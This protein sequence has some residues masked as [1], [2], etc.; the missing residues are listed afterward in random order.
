MTQPRDGARHLLRAQH[1]PQRALLLERGAELLLG[2]PGLF[3]ERL[4]GAG[5]EVGI[6]VA[7]A[8]GVDGD[9]ALDDLE[10]ERP[11]E[12]DEPVLGR[13][14]GRD[15]RVARHAGR[16]RD[17]DDAAPPGLQHVGECAPRATVGAREVH[18]E[19]GLPAVRLHLGERH[20]VDRP[21]VV[22][23]H[24]HRPE[25]RAGFGERLLD[26][27]FV[28]H[29]RGHGREALGM[30]VSEFVGE[31]LER[32]RRAAYERHVGAEGGQP[33]G[34]RGADP[35]AAAGDDGVPPV[36]RSGVGHAS[37]SCCSASCCS[38]AFRRSISRSNWRLPARYWLGHHCSV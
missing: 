17:V 36:E 8:D 32:L 27:G 18:V 16:A 13:A 5:H 37:A 22:D 14:V 24:G 20:A 34:D 10:R 7:R 25:R 23:E 30:G 38:I 2:L 28:G 31:G 6:G 3:R 35:P 15:V 26:A 4:H 9:A 21:R 11:R 29:I 12:P 1:P 19:H 33:A